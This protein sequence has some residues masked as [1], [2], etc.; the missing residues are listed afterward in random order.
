MEQSVVHARETSTTTGTAITIVTPATS[1]IPRTSTVSEPLLLSLVGLG[2]TIAAS[3]RRRASRV[4]QT[5]RR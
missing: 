2:L 1:S 3:R 4:S 5:D